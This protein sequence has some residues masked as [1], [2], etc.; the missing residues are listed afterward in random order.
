MIKFRDL[1][2]RYK[3]TAVSL[4]I[5][6]TILIL[7]TSAFV[8][9][10]IATLRQTMLDKIGVIQGMIG[11][12]S[13]GPLNF[14]YSAEEAKVLSALKVDPHVVSARI[15]DKTGQHFASYWRKPPAQL[16][17]Y[18]ALKTEILS[19]MAK[20]SFNFSLAEVELLQNFIENQD[21][22]TQTAEEQ[23]EV[24]DFLN[25]AK[26]TFPT[27][28]Q[29]RLRELIRQPDALLPLRLNESYQNLT[30]T[31][32]SVAQPI[33]WLG[34]NQQ[35]MEQLGWVLLVTDL[36]ALHSRINRYIIMVIAVLI[37][38]VLIAF[39]FSSRAHQLLTQPILNLVSLAR[40]VSDKQDY[41]VRGNY[42]SQ[43]EVG[44]LF[45]GFNNMLMVIKARDD[46]LEKANEDLEKKVAERTLELKKANKQLA[47]QAFHDALTNLPNR[48]MFVKQVEVAIK[49]AQENQ[50]CMAML[51]IDLDHFKYINDTLGHS[52]GDRILQ[53][54]AKRLLTCTRQ[55]EDMV[56][57]LGGDEFTVLLRNLKEPM[58]AG[59]VAGKILKSLA[60][61]F[62]YNTQDLYVTPSI[63]ISFYP[64][65]GRDVGNLMRNADS[66]MYAAK[67]QGRNNYQFYRADNN[68]AS[69]NRLHMENKLRQALEFDEFEVWYQ[70]RF[71]LNTGLL[72]GAEALV[73]WR[74]PDLNLVPP[75]QFIPLAEDTGLII[76]IGEKV[77]RIAC[78]DNMIWKKTEHRPITVSV[79][80]SARQFVQEDLL[81]K[82]E[83]LLNELEMPA[84]RLELELTESLIMPNA[85]E[86]I[87]TLND[88][89]KMG[90]QISVDDF[91]TGYSSLSYL[92]R[93]P[94]DIL[95]IDQSFVYELGNNQDD[96][97]L[98]TAIIA[99]AHKL[100]LTVV[101]EGVET[102]AQLDFLKNNQCDFAQG[103]L[104]GK[105]V[106]AAIFKKLLE[107]DL[108][109][110]SYPVAVRVLLPDWG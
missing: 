109:I 59:I 12:M 28:V 69:A 9:N 84:A 55:P 60:L 56:A 64:E 23:Q 36:E 63:G 97:T 108:D 98:V 13:G 22:N 53:E 26:E 42:H 76:P 40:Q 34:P 62:R 88:L 110:D 29:E 107:S 38:S 91:G 48:A 6:G 39:L 21:A 101:A 30:A 96:A 20:Q 93:F 78:Q 68:S 4:L 103:Y 43:D 7:S 106:P 89:K 10:D 14:Q 1:S 25:R 95:K 46:E 85:E 47:Y 19:L 99:M 2:I 73:R 54:V 77:L 70:P 57:R 8:I 41:S 75:A 79:N 86:T 52:A 74:S 17:S 5:S 15:Y 61:P 44:V 3:L 66:S 102:Q 27:S 37:G 33:E 24:L 51:F 58:N 87:E 83:V 16:N 94:I 80:L 45:D 90:V 67:L 105:P 35:S 100:R 72:V 81:G 92:R 32:F 82:I 31:Y 18:N 49:H 11:H 50:Q 65:D 71:E 104:F